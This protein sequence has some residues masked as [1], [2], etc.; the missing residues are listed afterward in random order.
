MSS[1][2][3]GLHRCM[4]GYLQRVC[5][6]STC[7]IV[8]HLQLLQ[9]ITSYQRYKRFQL[10]VSNQV[11]FCHN[12]SGTKDFHLLQDFIVK[13]LGI[14]CARTDV[15]HFRRSNKVKNAPGLLSIP[16]G[17]GSKGGVICFSLFQ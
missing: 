2:V 5:I 14:T 3:T 6:F 13:F 10:D 7:E 16:A 15:T 1:G 4:D 9:R 12:Q 17:D 11:E 8:L